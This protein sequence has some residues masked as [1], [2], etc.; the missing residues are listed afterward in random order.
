MI[1]RTLRPSST[2][3]SWSYLDRATTTTND[4]GQPIVAR[5]RPRLFARPTPHRGSRPPRGAWTW[6][7]G[8]RMLPGSDGGSAHA[9][10]GR[11]R[12]VRARA[13]LGPSSRRR[14]PLGQDRPGRPHPCRGCR[15]P[16][17]PAG[18]R[19][20]S[21]RCWTKTG[22][23]RSS[24]RNALAVSRPWSPK[25]RRGGQQLA[26]QGPRWPDCSSQRHPGAEPDAFNTDLID[27][28]P[29]QPQ[30]PPASAQLMGVGLC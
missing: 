24:S 19:P 15:N 13:V 26:G 18:S 21:W 27:Q 10:Q 9:L 23:K 1:Q 4:T 11:C 6:R 16:P 14:L 17:P 2:T 12:A 3:K 8:R 25:A 20:T 29:Q 22:K 5:D 28:P 7:P 30:A